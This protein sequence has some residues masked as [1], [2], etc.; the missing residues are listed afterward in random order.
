MH[1]HELESLLKE[2]LTH[3]VEAH[4]DRV[5]DLE[6]EVME[7]LPTSRPNPHPRWGVVLAG[8]VAAAAVFMIGLWIGLNF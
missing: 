6:Y 4:R 1:E 3:Y 7:E 8:A 5:A 2:A